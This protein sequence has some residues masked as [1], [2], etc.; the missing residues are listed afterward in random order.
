MLNGGKITNNVPAS[1]TG[2]PGTEVTVPLVEQDGYT[3]EGWYDAETGG[4]MN[5][6]LKMACGICSSNGMWNA[7]LP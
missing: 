2:A 3:F 1:V 4:Y 7:I 5:I 6:A